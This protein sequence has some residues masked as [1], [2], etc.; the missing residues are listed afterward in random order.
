[1]SRAPLRPPAS[2]AE[3]RRRHLGAIVVD[4]FFG[5]AAKLAGA[6]PLAAPAFHGVEVIRADLLDP[7]QVAKLPD[8]PNVEAHARVELER[9]AAGGRLR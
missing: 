1:M 3:E 6:L 7:N 4:G 5:G 9:V 8:A 2:R